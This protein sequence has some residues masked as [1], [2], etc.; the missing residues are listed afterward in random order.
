[1][2]LATSTITYGILCSVMLVNQ[3]TSCLKAFGGSG[4]SNTGDDGG[5][6]TVA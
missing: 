4:C 1:L 3:N 2:I 5:S 6:D